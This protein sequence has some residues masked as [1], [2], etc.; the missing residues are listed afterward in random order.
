[1]FADDEHLGWI[2]QRSSHLSVA[3][4]QLCKLLSLL[5][6]YGLQA[7][8]SKSKCILAIRG[9]GAEKARSQHTVWVENAE[10]KPELRLRLPGYHKRDGPP[11]VQ[12]LDCMGI[13]LCYSSYEELTMTKRLGVAQGSFDRLRKILHNR[14]VLTIPQ[15]LKLWQAIVLP[16]ATYG[17]LITGLTKVSME[18]FHGMM[19]RH[20]RSISNSPL[21]IHRE[22]NW[23]LGVRLGIDLPVHYL[24]KLCT[25][26]I[27]KLAHQLQ[28]S[29]DA[30]MNHFTLDQ[31]LKRTA[32]QLTQMELKYQPSQSGAT[33]SAGLSGESFKCKECDR[34]FT[35]QASLRQHVSKVHTGKKKTTILLSDENAECRQHAKDGMPICKHCGEEFRRW[36]GLKRHITLDRCSVYRLQSAEGRGAQSGDAQAGAEPSH[37]PPMVSQDSL[38]VVCRRSLGTRT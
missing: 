21:H 14:R 6:K 26:R 24:K 7:N 18:R 36:S 38:Q 33:P 16:A 8:A 25:G 1:M 31:M 34:T 3:V 35:T 37:Q 10:G 28:H 27:Q 4:G 23:D 2:V 29:S 13:V 15:R 30:M 9:S 17:L 20:I 12:T 32:G 19:L 5:R 11:I 22:S